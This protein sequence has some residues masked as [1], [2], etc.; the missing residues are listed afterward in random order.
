MSTI[1]SKVMKILPQRLPGCEPGLRQWICIHVL[2]AMQLWE[3]FVNRFSIKNPNENDRLP[4]YFH[5][6]PVSAHPY[7]VKLFGSF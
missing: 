7:P 2:S 6:Y 3:M 4:F 5:S 1:F